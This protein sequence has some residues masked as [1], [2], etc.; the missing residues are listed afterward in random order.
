MKTLS[1]IAFL[2]IP[3]IFAGCTT[4]K[5]G[6]GT[7]G[8]INS[9]GT[10]EVKITPDEVVLYLGVVKKAPQVED[11]RKECDAVINRILAMADNPEKYGLDKEAFQTDFI[12][13]K[14][15]FVA[16]EGKSVF[17]GY[18]I[19][20]NIVITVHNTDRFD[21]VFT[22]AVAAGITH[23]HEVEINATKLA[24]LQEEA[25]DKALAD[26]R[27]NAEW[28]AK[29][30]GKK[31]VKIE[32]ISEGTTQ[33][34]NWYVQ[35]GNWDKLSFEE[36]QTESIGFKGGSQSGKTVGV[37]QSSAG[38]DKTLKVIQETNEPR[39]SF[40]QITISASLHATF[41]LAEVKQ[42]AG[43]E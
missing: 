18:V 1:I 25:K 43:A 38:Q 32:S 24:D 12:K 19:T 6:P 9:V 42:T 37:N 13:I 36:I 22:E 30:L 10:G 15:E 41:T 40:G 27:R 39:Y 7:T 14:R 17:D 35:R 29:K 26:A 34:L 21:D 33:V 8:R 20:K 3:L 28:H 2:C 4:T 23:I 16:R 31:I 11:A 5:A